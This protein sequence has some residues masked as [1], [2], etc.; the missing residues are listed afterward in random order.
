MDGA[1][2]K[3]TGTA[4]VGSVL[5]ASPRVWTENPTTKYRWLRKGVPIVNAT[6]GTYKL[7]TA[8]KDAKISVRVTG[9]RAGY[10]TISWESIAVTAR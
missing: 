7:K 10:T 5:T 4:K 8:D 1:A 3:V 6:A 2:P 9:S